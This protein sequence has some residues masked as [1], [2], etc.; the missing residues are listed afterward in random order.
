MGSED[1]LI[2]SI[3]GVL[4]KYLESKPENICEKY[5]EKLIA[6]V[7]YQVFHRNVYI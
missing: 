1:F 3:G 4:G 2:K 7:A 6:T 5:A